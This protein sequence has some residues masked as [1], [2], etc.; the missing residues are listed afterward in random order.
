MKKILALLL[1]SIIAIFSLLSCGGDDATCTEHV[2]SDANGKCDNCDA[3]VEIPGGGDGGAAA[4]VVLVKDGDALFSV[5]VA[6][7]ATTVVRD[8]ANDLIREFNQYYIEDRDV[9]MSQDIATANPGTEIIIGPVTTRGDKFNVDTHYLGYEGFA[10]K[11]V[12]G[13]IF[14]IA[15]G[16]TGYRKAIDYLKKSILKLNDY[17]DCIT[18]LT[19]SGDTAYESI[20]T[21]YTIEKI[22]IN[23]NNISEYVIAY[24]DTLKDEKSVATTL[25]DQLYKNTGVWLN[26]VK[27]DKLANDQKAI[28][29]EYTGE[30]KSRT[31][32]SGFVVYVDE[33]DNMHFEC[34]FPNLFND[35]DNVFNTTVEDTVI[36]VMMPKKKNVSFETGTVKEVDVRNV[37]YEAFGAKG[38]GETNDFAAI[39]ACHEYANTYGHTANATNGRTYRITET[40]GKVITVQT[41]VKWN[42]AK[43]IIDDTTFTKDDVER[44]TSI[45][46][47]KSNTDKV[48]Y[49][50]EDGSSVGNI[51][52][53]INAA[54]GIDAETCTK[55]D[56]LYCL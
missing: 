15:G 32:E 16:N 1:I 11:V 54:G 52:D 5:L 26:T 37:S 35:K 48:T 25:Q 53:A 55:L 8:Y 30:D 34:E 40:G 47:V 50:A 13:N 18:S 4:D 44:G 41:N 10:I 14:V 33:G 23:S 38:D 42:G 28:Y 17:D 20:Q 3:T 2:D 22:T 39:K 21:G 27:I 19:V 43:F 7:N 6:S 36:S 51:I 29:I 12:D 9:A 49:S 56:L 46:V 31:T 45:F 24:G